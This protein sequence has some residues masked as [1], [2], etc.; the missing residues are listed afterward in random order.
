MDVAV[1]G[2][3]PMGALD[4]AT[5]STFA[6]PTVHATASG[7]DLARGPSSGALQREFVAIGEE[8]EDAVDDAMA[9][10]A[11]ARRTSIGGVAPGGDGPGGGGA[12]AV[13]VADGFE[14]PPTSEAALG[15]S[16]A[17]LVVWMGDFN[18]RINGNYEEVCAPARCAC[19]AE[20][21]TTCAV[22]NAHASQITTRPALPTN[23]SHVHVCYQVVECANKGRFSDLLQNDQLRQEAS[24][25]AIFF[26]LVRIAA[27][28]PSKQVWGRKSGWVGVT[29]QGRVRQGST[30]FCLCV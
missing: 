29:G 11:Q 1:G 22:D 26:D 16:D 2:S 8:D 25:G 21:V 7:T 13:D 9:T 23:R 30:K 10:A 6:R 12:S 14:A 28:L 4:S 24:K 3:L 5:S 19:L 17:Q 20:D 27:G 15:M 18:Y